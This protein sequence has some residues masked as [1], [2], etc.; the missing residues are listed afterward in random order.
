METI[1]QTLAKDG[2][3]EHIAEREMLLLLD[4]LEQVI[5]AA[6]EL[7]QLLSACPNLTLLCTSRE[8]LRVQGEV[9]YSVPPLASPEA[10]S[11]FCE[12]S[13][14][15]SSE[16]VAELCA[17]LDNLPLAVELAAARTKALTPAQ[18]LERLASRLDL[19]KGGRD[20][21]PRQQTLRA[22]IAWSYELLSEEEQRVFRALAVFAGGCTLE[23]AE[24][25][26][27]AELD[28]MQSLVEKSLLRFS[29]GRYWMLETIQ[30]YADERLVEMGEL[31]TRKDRHV[32]FVLTLAGQLEAT[33]GSDAERSRLQVEQDNF[34]S[35]LAW[36]G[37][38]EN[39]EAQLEL[40]GRT[41]LFWANRGHLVEGLRWVESALARCR[42]E[43]SERRAK[44]LAGGAYFALRLGEFETMKN[45]ADESLGIART[46]D[47]PGSVVWPLIL[48]GLSATELGSYQ[49]AEELLR[50]AMSVAREAGD[51]ASVGIA[52]NN[53]GDIAVRQRDYA[54]AI[55]LF[56]GAIT[57]AGERRADELA[58]E[59]YNLA[60]CLY[61]TDQSEEAW[62]VALES[63]E[64]AVSIDNV[65]STADALVLLGALATRKGRADVG[66]TTLG[67]AEMLRSL[68]RENVVGAEAELLQKTADELVRILGP[69]AY[70]TALAHGRA[71]TPEQALEYA[72][73]SPD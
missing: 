10:V 18:I 50:E 72:R 52:M 56:E 4:N 36:A 38:R 9:E 37:Q 57:M 12:R 33:S 1:A 51:Q 70:A 63:L 68:A 54:R 34:R 15:E 17:R 6:P 20:A 16:E 23:A 59:T 65:I 45:Y 24:E 46:L 8:L 14:L 35:A 32:D 11:L 25:V 62:A 21:D 41:W 66:A 44:V 13:Q 49:D 29:N 22:T 3:A 42:H 43:P 71:M 60:L 2:L 53:L 39:T 7:S 58:T 5:A 28:T 48:L 26:C 64:L 31:A 47:R 69:N 30:E 19:L 73:S 55:P 61:Y 67:S 40:I 27:D